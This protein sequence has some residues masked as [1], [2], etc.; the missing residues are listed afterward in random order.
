MKE[1][2]NIARDSQTDD[3]TTSLMIEGHAR[4]A[5]DILNTGGTASYASPGSLTAN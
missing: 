4:Q 3:N 1:K 2:S 5:K